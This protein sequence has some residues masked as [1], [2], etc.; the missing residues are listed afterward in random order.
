MLNPVTSVIHIASF[1][2]NIGISIKTPLILHNSEYNQ[3]V[4]YQQRFANSFRPKSFMDVYYLSQIFLKRS[5]TLATGR[6]CLFAII[7]KQ[8]AVDEG[9]AF[10][11]SDALSGGS[12]IPGTTRVFAVQ[13]HFSNEISTLRIPLLSAV[14]S[15]YFLGGARL[16]H[17]PGRGSPGSRVI[18]EDLLSSWVPARKI[19]PTSLSTSLPRPGFTDSSVTGRKSQLRLSYSLLHLAVGQLVLTVRACTTN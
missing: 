3:T 2:S 1:T 7:Y 6:S 13:F 4:I 17:R 11:V 9:R 16:V 18:L 10:D 8:I 12:R 15:N 19:R 5:F 14:K